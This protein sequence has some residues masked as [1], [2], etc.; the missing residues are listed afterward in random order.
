MKYIRREGH[1]GVYDFWLP[2]ANFVRVSCSASTLNGNDVDFVFLNLARGILCIINQAR[3]IFFRLR[4][5]FL[6]RAL[7]L[8]LFS[9]LNIC[10]LGKYKLHL[11]ILEVTFILGLSKQL[12]CALRTNAYLSLKISNKTLKL[13]CCCPPP[14]LPAGNLQQR[15]C[16]QK[17]AETK[18]T[19]MKL[20]CIFGGILSFV[21]KEA[22]QCHKLG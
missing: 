20:C 17:Q 12:L 6:M 22:Q 14:S 1:V 8:Y 15:H 4:L 13:S 21:R 3:F 18:L 7:K 11:K 19:L 2:P 16:Y 5:F 9:C 10:V